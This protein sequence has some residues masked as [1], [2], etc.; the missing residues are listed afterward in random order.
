MQIERKCVFL[1]IT[2]NIKVIKTFVRSIPRGFFGGKGA[3][4]GQLLMDMSCI[5]ESLTPNISRHVYDH[6]F[7]TLFK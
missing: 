2:F 1:I 4:D 6:D 5:S 7:H 3:R